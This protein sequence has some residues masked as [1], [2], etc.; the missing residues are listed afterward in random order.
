MR[1]I[2]L[3][4]VPD[5]EQLED[6]CPRTT[7]IAAL[8]GDQTPLTPLEDEFVFPEN[9]SGQTPFYTFTREEVKALNIAS[10]QVYNLL[11][12]SLD[13]L[14]DEKYRHLIP[15][16]YGQEFIQA[17]P[18]FVDYAIY[19]FQNEHEAIYGRFDIA[20]DFEQ[21][22]VLKFY[23]GNLDTPTMYY[24]SVVMQHHLLT[25]L[26]QE[27]AQ[28]NLHQ[29]N[30]AR[31]I[32][33]V[34]GPQER[35]IAFL[36]DT[37]ITEDCITTELLFHTFNDHCDDIV[38]FSDINQLRYDFSSSRNK[39]TLDEIEVDVIFALYP[40]EDMVVDLYA[41]S[42]NPL[43]EWRKWADKTRFLEPAWRWFISNK[44][45]WAWLTYLKD[46]LAADDPALA[47]FVRDNEAAWQYVIPSYMEKPFW[48]KDYVRKP[49]QGRMSNNIGFY[50]NDQLTHET[51]GFY[52]GD[53]CIY[54][55][56]CPTTSADN[57]DTR[58]IVC[59][60]LA[61]WDQGL[62]LDMES[63]GIAVREFTGELLQV[64]H[65]RFM[66]HIVTD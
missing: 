16:F 4:V 33:K 41:E 25:R 56:I 20:Y 1:K 48:L 58:A 55:A 53:D 11:A 51:D 15:K 42:P 36:C 19:T 34:L 65:E 64:K 37:N 21:G 61:P 2:T 13:F 26:G 28:Y 7:A 66:P 43:K 52:A 27:Q 12:D 24:D 44:G 50:E 47:Q 9:Q 45:V 49:L 5:Y 6:D 32:R 14:F 18:E 57:G 10:E 17:Y 23:E 30:L 22:K 59:T 62:A 38:L 31:N 29:E 35:R 39:W 40:W 8:H 54:Q 63:S 3:D 60:W 46:V